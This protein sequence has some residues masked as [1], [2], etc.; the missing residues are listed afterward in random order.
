MK[1]FNRLFGNKEITAKK[2]PCR[3]LSERVL[4]KS[5]ISTESSWGITYTSS[6]NLSATGIF[7]ES[8]VPFEVDSI[9]SLNFYLPE[10]DQWMNIKGQVANVMLSE[11]GVE[12]GLGIQ[13][14]ELTLPQKK[15]LQ[16]YVEMQVIEKWFDKKQL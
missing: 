14:I 11:D 6:G 15:M 3:R 7:L 16:E 10:F 2:I 4:F 12:M 1:F 5:F 8:R 13:F 9:L